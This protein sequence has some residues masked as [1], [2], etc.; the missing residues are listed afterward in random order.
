MVLDNYWKLKA[1]ASQNHLWV[2]GGV[3][4][5]YDTSIYDMDG[6]RIV[7]IQTSY[8]GTSSNAYDAW[9][10]LCLRS[11]LNFKVGSGAVAP[12]SSD[13]ALTADITSN[14]GALNMISNTYADN[15]LATDIN[16]S[17]INATNSTQTINEIGLYISTAIQQ[18][19]GIRKILLVHELLDQPINVP[20]SKGFSITFRW[21]EA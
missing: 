5:W 17:G 10:L 9:K 18:S 8:G 7:R 16:I 4:L 21:V 1:T 15:G 20:A 13:Y 2:D 19:T 3:Q 11:N 14:F 12:T 6:V